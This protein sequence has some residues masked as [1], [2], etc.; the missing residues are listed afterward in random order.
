[1]TTRKL[2]IA[3]TLGSFLAKPWRF[4]LAAGEVPPINELLIWE[5]VRV[6][7]LAPP[8]G[9]RGCAESPACRPILKAEDHKDRSVLALHA[10]EKDL[11][12][13]PAQVGGR[14]EDGAL[15]GFQRHAQEAPNEPCDFPP[16]GVGLH[17]GNCA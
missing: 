7:F 14:S 9:R 1:M 11:S 8:L 10:A 12:A 16:S 6:E 2:H 17:A 3:V 13:A 5:M 4:S 15:L